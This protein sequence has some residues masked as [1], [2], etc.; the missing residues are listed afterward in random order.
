MLH[1]TRDYLRCATLRHPFTTCSLPLWPTQDPGVYSG[2]TRLGCAA[3]FLDACA[4]VMAAAPE[5]T[6]PL[7]I[8]HSPDDTLTDPLGSREF[9]EASSS[10]DKRYVSAVGMWHDLIQEPGN[11][12]LLPQVCSP[13]PVPRHSTQ[14]PG[15]VTVACPGLV[16]FSVVLTLDD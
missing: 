9:L 10:E 3:Q 5:A 2:A 6:F 4:H 1:D 15:L 8:F 13:S 7:L 11:E 12:A 14:F 16:Q